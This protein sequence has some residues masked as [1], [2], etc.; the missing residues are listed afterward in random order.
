MKRIAT[1]V[2]KK[3][4]SLWHGMKGRSGRIFVSRI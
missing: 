3:F 2:P 4:I 1:T